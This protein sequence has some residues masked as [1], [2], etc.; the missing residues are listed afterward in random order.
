MR[1][2]APMHPCAS[3]RTTFL[4]ILHLVVSRD[5]SQV[6]VLYLL[7]QLISHTMASFWYHFSQW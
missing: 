3:Q 2:C 5:R 1:A 7:I 6:V 4:G